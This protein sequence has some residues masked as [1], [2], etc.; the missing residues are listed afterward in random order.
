[1]LPAAEAIE[2]D[3]ASAEATTGWCNIAMMLGDTRA[4]ELALLVCMHAE[5]TAPADGNRSRLAAHRELCLLDLGLAQATRPGPVLL[6]EIGAP[7][8]TETNTDA[9]ATWRAE[10][11][12][13]F[14]GD[15]TRAAQAILALVIAKVQP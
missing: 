12:A 15:L 10:Q 9:L 3:P 2:R 4:S 8:L 14:D 11:L 6:A 1:M 5:T 7:G 13:P